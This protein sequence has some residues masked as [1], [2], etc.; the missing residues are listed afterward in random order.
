MNYQTIAVE[1]ESHLVHLVLNRPQLG[2]MVDTRLAAELT[3]ACQQ[4]NQDDEARAVILSGAP[5]GPFSTG[6]DIRELL[7]I[8][9]GKGP[10]PASELPVRGPAAASSR[11]IAG[12][13]VP[14]IAAID[15]LALGA[16]LE[17]ALSCDI[18]VVSE[19]AQF[20]FP[21][22]SVGLLP[23]GGGTQRLPRLVGRG[24]ALELLFLGTLI[25][26]Q[27][28]HRIGLVNCLAPSPK[29]MATAREL[30]QLALSRGPIALRYAKEAVSQGIDLTLEQ[31]LRL[32]ADLNVILQTT[33]D[34]AE[35][36]KAFLE[37]RTPKFKGV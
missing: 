24:K 7:N 31:G 13:N 18:R 22:T 26:A 21:Q 17:L 30:A 35:G 20:G 11:A 32:E 29:L 15:L 16:G 28:A 25:D 23:S 34:R 36:V 6:E 33:E 19:R 2:N 1:K 12:I 4:I 5:G 27:E 3:E 9:K 10:L 8:M 37:K 14:V